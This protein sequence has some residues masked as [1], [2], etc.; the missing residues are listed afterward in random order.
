MCWS[1]AFKKSSKSPQSSL[2]P[3]INALQNGI[4]EDFRYLEDWLDKYTYL[5]ELGNELEPLDP[6]YKTEEHLIKGCQS[7]VWFNMVCEKGIVKLY[8]DSDALIVKG[9]ASLLIQVLSNQPAENIA[10]ADLYFLDEIGVKQH[11][12]PQRANGLLAMIDAIKK[13]ATA[14]VNN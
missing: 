4:V 14:C 6:T 12:S 11:L 3:D 9:L 10:R 1:R 8:A 7:R 2:M 13:F 5:V